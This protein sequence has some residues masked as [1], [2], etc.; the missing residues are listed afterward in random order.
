[1]KKKSAAARP[2]PCGSGRPYRACCGPL[3]EGGEADDPAQLMRSR[4]AAFVLGRGDYLFRTLHESHPL[5]A[6]PEA[7]V[8]GELSSARR[9]LR[10]QRLVVHDAE[11]TGARGRVLFTAHVFE[12]GKDRS[13]VE[14]SDFDRV[15]GAWRYRDGLTVA[16]AELTEAPSTIVA[17]EAALSAPPPTR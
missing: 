15:D 2:C 16:R 7:D 10:Y 3:H 8:V 11:V 4:F 9:T 17:F 1:M 13:F 6:R 5:R 14:L 12:S